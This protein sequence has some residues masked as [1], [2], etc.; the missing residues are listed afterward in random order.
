M[1]KVTIITVGR[2]HSKELGVLVSEYEKRLSSVFSIEWK[3]IEPQIGKMSRDEQCE[4]ESTEIL[5]LLDDNCNV[6]LLDERGTQ[7]EN[8][9]LADKIQGYVEQTKGLVFIIGGAFGVS[10][11]LRQRANFVWSLS[12]LVLPHEIVRLIII[13]QLYRS[14]AINS[15]LPYHHY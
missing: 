3:F 4:R 11:N 6:I 9:N 7:L 14:Y 2:K 12:K 5:R 8:K 15:S 13:E 10:D 1:K